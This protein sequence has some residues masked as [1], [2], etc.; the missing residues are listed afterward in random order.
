MIQVGG[1][2]GLSR[3]HESRGCPILSRFLRKG[4]IS[5]TYSQRS[6]LRSATLRASLRQQGN[7]FFACLPRAY[8]LGYIIP[9][10]RRWLVTAGCPAFPVPHET[11]GIGRS[12]DR[13]ASHP[14]PR[15]TGAVREPRSSGGRKIKSAPDASAR[16]STPSRIRRVLKP[17]GYFHPGL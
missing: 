7:E 6:F 4:G 10:L 3:S 1:W 12:G 9:R 2:P 8:A 11:G 15:K 17:K 5:M 13:P 16:I 14:S